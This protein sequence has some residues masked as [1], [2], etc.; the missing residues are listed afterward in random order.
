[1]EI[2]YTVSARRDTGLYNAKI[3]IWL[4]LASEVMLFGGLF[5][6]YVF[7]RVG[8]REGVDVPWPNGIDVHG[9]Y[10]WLGF[11]NTLVLILSSVFVVMAWIQ[12]K[13]RNYTKY[14]FYM[15][16]VLLCSVVFMAFK[17]VEY[18]SKLT[19]HYGARLVDGTVLD[20]ELGY[21]EEHNCKGDVITFLGSEADFSLTPTGLNRKPDPY[22]LDLIVSGG[23]AIDLQQ[24]VPTVTEKEVTIGSTTFPVESLEFVAGSPERVEKEKVPGILAKRR[25]EYRAASEKNLRQQ[26]RAY[27]RAISTA[28]GEDRE[29][30]R[31]ARDG[32]VAVPPPPVLKGTWEKPAT[33]QFRKYDVAGG[34]PYAAS[35][36]FFRGNTV[37]G[38]LLDDSVEIL[39]HDI[40]LQLSRDQE[41]SLAWTYLGKEY[42]AGFEHH[43]E[44]VRE[45]YKHWTDRGGTIPADKLYLW[46][47]A[48][49]S[50]SKG[51]HGGDKKDGKYHGDQ[52]SIPASDVFFQGN[53]GPKWGPYFAIYFTMTGLHGLHVVGGAL[54][55]GYFLFF[56]R[57]L[58]RKNPEH[59][60]NRV[61]VGGLFWHFVDLVWIFLFPIMYLM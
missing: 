15:V 37:K 38:K 18:N 49:P 48:H 41:E 29:L 44:E 47:G 60:A 17:S 3:G 50:E 30:I 13:L 58:Y 20:G 14:Q 61:E 22:F 32:L 11:T 5:S 21:D 54:V 9:K 6:A 19:H 39:V 12:L 42:K 55:L 23:G 16:G 2:P 56:G 34:K 53:H 28:S 40:D 33:L 51:E 7:L 1:M 46:K 52:V 31:D 27:Q 4:F 36:P 57:K 35:V 8:A 24:P 10:I 25:L 45:R 26:K 59:L 43:Q